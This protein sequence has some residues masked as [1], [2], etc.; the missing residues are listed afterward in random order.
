L[1]EFCVDSV[2]SVRGSAHVAAFS[3]SDPNTCPTHVS[4]NRLPSRVICELEGAIS[5]AITYR[6]GRFDMPSRFFQRGVRGVRI[7]F[8]P[9]ELLPGN[10]VVNAQRCLQFGS[11]PS[12]DSSPSG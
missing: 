8:N 6:F 3:R 1:S 10:H 2:L 4:S 11:E 7:R 12:G 9:Y 5:V